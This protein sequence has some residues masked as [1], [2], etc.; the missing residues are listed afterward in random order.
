[1]RSLRGRLIL[2]HILPLLIV[3]PLIGVVLIYLL[4]TQVVLASLSLELAEKAAV[5]AEMAA[6]EPAIWRDTAQAQIFVTRFSAYQRS[7]VGLVDLECK[8]LAS[9]DPDDAAQLGQPLDSPGL[10]DEVRLG[11]RDAR[12]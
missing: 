10:P 5:T 4:E 6:D 12:L 3:V 1:M 7:A 9:N 8:L 11:S 2:S